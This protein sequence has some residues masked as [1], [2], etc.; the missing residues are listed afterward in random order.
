MANSVYPFFPTNKTS[1]PTQTA[2]MPAY[3]D[4]TTGFPIY[5]QMAPTPGTSSAPDIDSAG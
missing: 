3:I 4:P 1:A 5:G 2:P